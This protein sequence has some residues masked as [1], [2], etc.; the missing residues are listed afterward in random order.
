MVEREVV[1]V[2]GEREAAAGELAGD[3]DLVVVDVL[4]VG[5]AARDEDRAR[6]TS[7]AASAVPTPA[8]A[9]SDVGIADRLG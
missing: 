2:D 6:P 9:T 8:W 7:S 5:Q 4:A 1:R 3:L